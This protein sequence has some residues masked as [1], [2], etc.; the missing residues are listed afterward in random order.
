MRFTSSYMTKKSIKSSHE[1]GVLLRHYCF[2]WLKLKGVSM[3]KQSWIFVVTIYN[4]S[5]VISI[6]N[7]SLPCHQH[8]KRSVSRVIHWNVFSDS[9]NTAWI[10]K[11]CPAASVTRQ[12]SSAGRNRWVTAALYVVCFWAKLHCITKLEGWCGADEISLTRQTWVRV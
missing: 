10:I 12:S 8:R 6:H 3:S 4:T 1:A 5:L 7:N 11:S 9:V 2:H